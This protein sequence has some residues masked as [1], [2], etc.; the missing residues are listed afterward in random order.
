MHISKKRTKCLTSLK[1]HDSLMQKTSCIVYLGDSIVT[2][3]SCE[4]TLRARELKAIGFISQI[5]SILKSVSLGMFF[6]QTALILRESIFI[7]GILTNVESWNFISEKGYKILEDS[8]VRLFSEIFGS[9]SNRVLFYIETGKIPIR[10]TIA[11]RRL[12]YLWHLLSRKE[13]ELISK[14]Y[15]IQKLKQTSK[16]WYQ[17]ICQEKQK[18]AI[19]LSDREIQEMSKTKYKK[20]VNESVN[21][22]AYS[23][24]VKTASEQSKC[25]DIVKNINIENISIQKYLVTEEL[26]QEEKQLLFNLRSHSFPVKCNSRYL[27]EDMSCRACME[28]QYEES[29]KHFAQTCVTFQSERNFKMLNVEDIFGT[30]QKQIT[31]IKSFKIIARKWKLILEVK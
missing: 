11:K 4:E 14:V 16:D 12:M 2:S 5:T 23:R 3:G 25:R 13:S 18:Y 20:L 22:F 9:K 27:F 28:P 7:N 6:F 24:L 8:D 26:Y 1:V 30:L 29:E 10:F 15:H 17:M 31:F 21:K 19:H